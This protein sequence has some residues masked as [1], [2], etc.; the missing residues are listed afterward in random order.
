M[1]TNLILSKTAIRTIDFYNA[2]SP[3]TYRM[4]IE[5]TDGKGNLGRQVFRYIV[6]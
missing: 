5:G 4:V 1:Q 3:G 6:Q 2:D